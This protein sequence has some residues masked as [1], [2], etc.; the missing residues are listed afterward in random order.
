MQIHAASVVHHP[1]DRVYLAYRDE[2][3]AIATF[4]ANI[5]EIRVLA[6]EDREG[7]VRLHNEWSGKGEIPKVAQRIITPDMVK[8]DDHADWSDAE[9]LG[10]WS[11]ST[12][13]F[14]ESVRCTGTTRIEAHGDAASRI[15]LAGTLDINV[16]DVPGVPR[17][18]ASSL[19]PQ[20]EKF[21]I[22]LITPNLEQ[23]NGALERYLD[24][25]R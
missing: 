13:F 17:F 19:A 2:L 25:K 23:V 9:R 3:P 10:R 14:T 7:G 24:S 12:R 4:M 15:T 8:W 6:R 20:V 11:I 21:I 22:A 1:A 16:G 5:K 18:L